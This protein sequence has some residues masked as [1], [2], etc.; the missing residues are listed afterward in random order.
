MTF[1]AAHAQAGG[2]RVRRGRRYG[3]GG[4]G[5]EDDRQAARAVA[6][7]ERIRRRPGWTDLA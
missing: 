1:D 2:K 3:A 6:D 4:S 7:G 5:G